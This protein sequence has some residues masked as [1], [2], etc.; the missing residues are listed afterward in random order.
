MGP[1][2]GTAF[3]RPGRG[4]QRPRRTA[5][6]SGGVCPPCLNQAM[7]STTVRPAAVIVMAMPSTTWSPR[8]LTQA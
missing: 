3:R 1:T 6:G 5:S 2:T 4:N 8:W 7:P